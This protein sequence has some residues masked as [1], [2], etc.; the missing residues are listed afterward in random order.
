MGGGTPVSTISAAGS[1]GY[2]PVQQSAPAQ[3]D[4][5]SAALREERERQPD[6]A[7]MMKDAREQIEQ[8][9]EQF[10]L[11]KN[12]RR[13]GDAAIMACSRLARARSPGEVDAASGYARRQIAQLRAAKRSD[14]DNAERIQAVINQL[15]KTV[16]RAGRKR[17]E[18]SQERL[19]EKRQARLAREKRY[20]DSPGVRLYAGGRGGQPRPGPAP[21]LPDGAAPAADR[22]HRT[23]P[24]HRG[25]R[26]PAVRLRRRRTRPGP[27]DQCGGISEPPPC[28]QGGGICFWC[29]K[30]VSRVL[31]FK[32]AIYLDAPLLTRSSR[33]PGTA[34]PACMSL[35]GVAPDRVYSDGRFHAIG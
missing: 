28:C 22:P 32:T 18:L 27:G 34:G 23:D 30:P 5:L 7:E 25:R 16:N 13:Y 17:R 2:Y 14:S 35:H 29:S 19:E 8:R 24:V 10:K 26:H 12:S 15:Q 6:L 21:G 3:D 33:L 1:G 9:K 31:S 20:A 4:G 11:P